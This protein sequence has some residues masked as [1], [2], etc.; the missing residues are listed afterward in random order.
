MFLERDGFFRDLRGK[1]HSLQHVRQMSLTCD[2]TRGKK[3]VLQATEAG[4]EKLGPCVAIQSLYLPQEHDKWL[5]IVRK[6]R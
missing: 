2:I 1:S 4:H 5:Q 3:I 6:L